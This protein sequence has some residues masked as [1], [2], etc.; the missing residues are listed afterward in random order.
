MPK[1]PV[2][3][4]DFSFLVLNHRVYRIENIIYIDISIFNLSMIYLIYFDFKNV[5]NNL[6]SKIRLEIIEINAIH[7]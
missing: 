7:S 2:Y 6:S 5:F 1:L 4:F 3:I